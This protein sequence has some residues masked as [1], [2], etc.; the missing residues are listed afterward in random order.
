MMTRNPLQEVAGWAS[1]PPPPEVAADVNGS[2]F[3]LES[4]IARHLVVR[5]G[6]LPWDN[7][8]RKWELETCPFNPEHTGGC[9]VVTEGSN[10][11]IGFKCQH[12]GCAD[13]HW[14]DVRELFDGARIKNTATEPAAGDTAPSDRRGRSE[15]NVAAPRKSF[16]L[17]RPGSLSE[18]RHTNGTR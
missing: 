13:R 2:G 8:G 1:D 9:A 10:G 5:R 16:G 18:A 11:A 12:N 14:R 15:L 3:N 4:F 6:P 7:R 17:G